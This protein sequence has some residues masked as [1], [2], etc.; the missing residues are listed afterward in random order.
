MMFSSVNIFKKTYRC[1]ISY[2]CN[3]QC[4]LNH[5]DVDPQIQQP[6][7]TSSCLTFRMVVRMFWGNMRHL[8]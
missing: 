2:L 5:R 8:W 7:E 4:S 3:I 1:K 6:P